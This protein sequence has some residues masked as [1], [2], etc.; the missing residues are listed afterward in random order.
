M[1]PEPPRRRLKA[2]PLDTDIDGIVPAMLRRT[3]EAAREAALA[4]G[5]RPP[6]VLYTVPTGQ[7]PT[8]GVHSRV[9]VRR[10]GGD[11]PWLIGWLPVL[12]EV[13]VYLST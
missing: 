4:D 1:N 5:S 11:V 13:P 9:P 8:G 10:R 6:R 3:L 7:N 2:V 12:R